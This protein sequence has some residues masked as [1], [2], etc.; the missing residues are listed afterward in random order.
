MEMANQANSLLTDSHNGEQD[1]I[2]HQFSAQ[3][4]DLGIQK[5][6]EGVP[7]YNHVKLLAE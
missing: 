2:P 5:Y 6:L 4:K 3:Y 1:N 7:F